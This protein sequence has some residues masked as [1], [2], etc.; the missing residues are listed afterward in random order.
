[1]STSGSSKS[2]SRRIYGRIDGSRGSRSHL[3]PLPR[4][5][6]ARHL[7]RRRSG[8]RRRSAEVA[9]LID[10]RPTK[11]RMRYV[12]V[13]GRGLRI[14]EGKDRPPHPRPRRQ[15]LAARPRHRHSS[16]L[17]R[18]GK[19]NAAQRKRANSLS[20]ARKFAQACKAVLAHRR[21]GMLRMRRACAGS[22]QGDRGPGRPGRARSPPERQ[23]RDPGAGSGAGSSPNCSGWP[24]SGDMRLA[25]PRTSSSKNSSIGPTA[26][27]AW[28]CRRRFR[29]AIG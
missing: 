16:K 27:T 23:E 9:C 5:L 1:M 17:P 14:A 25:G 8:R 11:S 26:S 21:E 6:N 20:H 2:A 10:A 15:R 13:I 7:Q 3:R 24:K 29:P 28:R 22:V 12:Q 19:E 4:R 18:H